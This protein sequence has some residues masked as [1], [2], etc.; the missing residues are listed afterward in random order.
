MMLASAL[1]APAAAAE[2]P[3]AAPTLL[4][5]RIDSIIA[6]E[7]KGA[8]EIT[9][10]GAVPSGGW[11]G[12]RLRP[13]KAGPG[14]A[15]TIVV[16]FVATPPPPTQAVIE[17]LLPIAANARVKARRGIVAV[18]VVSGSNEITTQLLK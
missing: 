12:P 2:R 13:V 17:G 6:T 3:P 9:V 16:E 15:H 1:A 5:S 11:R 7:G 8:I 18:R 4:V 10:K 14:D